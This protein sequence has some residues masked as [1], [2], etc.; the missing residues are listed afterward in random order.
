MLLMR[1]CRQEPY[2]ERQSSAP[3]DYRGAGAE[4]AVVF[5]G[6]AIG[7][8]EFCR[9]I[10]TPASRFVWSTKRTVRSASVPGAGIVADSVPEKEFEE[11]CN[12][13]RAVRAAIEQAEEGLE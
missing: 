9:E 10:W 7:Y 1:S 6:W 4:Q 8:L 2:P 11:C 3:A 13:A 5:Y 12:K